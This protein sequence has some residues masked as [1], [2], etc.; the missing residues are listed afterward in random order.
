MSC[1][2]GYRSYGFLY[3]VL[4]LLCKLHLFFVGKRAVT[5]G[6]GVDSEVTE[7]VTEVVMEVVV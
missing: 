6:A 3:R 5:K 2:G 4:W 1:N 7:V